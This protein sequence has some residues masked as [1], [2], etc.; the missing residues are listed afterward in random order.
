M[1]VHSHG[2]VL[3]PLVGSLVPHGALMSGGSLLIIGTFTAYD[4]LS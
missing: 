4:S 3:L 1:M 2:M